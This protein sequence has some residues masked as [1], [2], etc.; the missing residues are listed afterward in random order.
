M[1]R[2]YLMILTIMS[3][4][5]LGCQSKI[6]TRTSSGGSSAAIDI[7]DGFEGQRL[8]FQSRSVI[9]FTLTDETISE[10]DTFSLTNISNSQA[11]I[12]NQQLSLVGSPLVTSGFSI[13]G[14]QLTQ[15]FEVTVKVYPSSPEFK[16]KFL[17]GENI[18]RLDIESNGGDKYHEQAITLKDFPMFGFGG[19]SFSTNVQRSGGFEGWFGGVVRPVV[20]AP[21]T[22]H[23]LRS[24]FFH[25]INH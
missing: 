4:A 12:E 5:P 3:L 7:G 17:F 19:A 24:G 15:G 10:G 20:K 21:E 2:I 22:G 25:S 1:R 8:F 14:H 23:V 13:S 18:L 6:S 9:S 11:L 16:D